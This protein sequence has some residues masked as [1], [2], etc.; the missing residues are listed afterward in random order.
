MHRLRAMSWRAHL[1]LRAF[2][3]LLL[4]IVALWPKSHAARHDRS[5]AHHAIRGQFTTAAARP[6]ADDV[7]RPRNVRLVDEDMDESQL[8]D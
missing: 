5:V 6:S 1:G 3:L 7:P 2:G 4:A 8:R